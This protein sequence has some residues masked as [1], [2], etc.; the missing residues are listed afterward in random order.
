[1][2]QAYSLN[3]VAQGASAIPFNNVKIE[4]GCTAQLSAPASI[5]LNKA[6]IYMVSCYASNEES[7]T[8]QLYKNGIPQ[9]EAQSTGTNPNFITLIQVSENNCRCNCY[10]SPTV[11]QVMNT[12]ATSATFDNIGICITKVC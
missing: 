11:L 8:I 3:V 10:S 9:P 12:P 2:L 4:K 7:T 1:M 5:N 6:G